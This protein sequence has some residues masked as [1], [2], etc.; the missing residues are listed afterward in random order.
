MKKKKKLSPSRGTRPYVF[1]QK[2]KP[3]LVQTCKMMWHEKVPPQRRKISH[4]FKHTFML[5]KNTSR[6]G[7]A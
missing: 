2:E 1:Q 6:V 4:D 5:I 3:D 7:E